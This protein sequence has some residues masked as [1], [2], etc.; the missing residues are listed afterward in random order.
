MPRSPAVSIVEQNRE[1]GQP[2]PVE[3]PDPFRPLSATEAIK[4][5]DAVIE[6]Y[7]P[8]VGHCFGLGAEIGLYEGQVIWTARNQLLAWWLTTPETYR[9]RLQQFDQIR[10]RIHRLDI[11]RRV[12]VLF[13]TEPLRSGFISNKT[14]DPTQ[15][16]GER[17][18]I[19]FYPAIRRR[20]S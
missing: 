8:E 6:H 5:V 19:S 4:A 14:H 2:S 13:Y 15:L 17:W 3:A 11:V 12:A 16:V 10:E 7:P 20:R 9:E 18:T 1:P